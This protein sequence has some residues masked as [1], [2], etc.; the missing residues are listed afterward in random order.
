MDDQCEILMDK[1]DLKIKTK[2]NIENSFK[3]DILK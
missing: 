3:V 2:P 1:M